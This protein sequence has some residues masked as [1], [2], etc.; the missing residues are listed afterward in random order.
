MIGVFITSYFYKNKKSVQISKDYNSKNDIPKNISLID[1]YFKY[2]N[3][4]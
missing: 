2:P 1:Y 4:K 3:F